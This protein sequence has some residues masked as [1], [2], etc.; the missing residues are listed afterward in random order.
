MGLIDE[1]AA[2]LLAADDGHG[3]A[4]EQLL[5]MPVGQLVEH[6]VA[7]DQAPP[8]ATPTPTP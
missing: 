8:M 6:V 1:I 4:E 3:A 5:A 2:L 7:D